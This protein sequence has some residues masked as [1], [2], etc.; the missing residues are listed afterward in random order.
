MVS[1]TQFRCH[2]SGRWINFFDLRPRWTNRSMQDRQKCRAWF[3]EGRI[4][5][6]EGTIVQVKKL[7]PDRASKVRTLYLIRSTHSFT[8]I[9]I[10][11]HRFWKLKRRSM[12][13]NGQLV[14][15][16]AAWIKTKRNFTMFGA[17][18]QADAQMVY[19]Y[20]KYKWIQGIIRYVYGC[21]IC[22]FDLHAHMTN[23]VCTNAQAKIATCGPWGY[24]SGMRGTAPARPKNT[25]TLSATRQR[26]H[27]WEKW[28]R[29]KEYFS[30]CGGATTSYRGSKE[31]AGKLHW[32][33]IK[34]TKSYVVMTR[35]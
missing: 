13:P 21:I 19:L 10:H 15:D 30:R 28:T 35:R 33:F 9:Y 11:S 8:Q 26:F 20:R 7:L 22:F 1:N 34:I 6:V 5:R 4:S 31:L 12:R 17:P 23:L 18:W 25:D 24:V 32:H 3:Q 2:R 14:S 27:C 29:V 16:L